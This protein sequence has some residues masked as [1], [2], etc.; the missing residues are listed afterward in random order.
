[1]TST[2]GILEID[3]THYAAVGSEDLP[4]WPKLDGS[5]GGLWTVSEHPVP[6]EFPFRRPEMQLLTPIYHPAVKNN[7]SSSDYCSECCK[8]QWSPATMFGRMIAF[9]VIA[10]DNPEDPEC[11]CVMDPKAKQLYEQNRTEFEAN[12]LKM[13]TKFSYPRSNAAIVSLKFAAKRI[14]C[15]QLNFDWAKINQL[16]LPNSLKKYLDTSMNSN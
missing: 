15:K 5:P 12:A 16:P 2:S 11:Y 3:T 9:F 14:I 7:G 13:V 1:M 4:H 6:K 10:I 8:E